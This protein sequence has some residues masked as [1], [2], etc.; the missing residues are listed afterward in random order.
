VLNWNFTILEVLLLMFWANKL[1]LVVD[2]ACIAD[3]RRHVQ[4]VRRL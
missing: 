1:G 4:E 3:F 2:G